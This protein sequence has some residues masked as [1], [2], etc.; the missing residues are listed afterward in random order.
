MNNIMK[1]SKDSKQ[2]MPRRE[3][4]KGSAAVSL[5]LTSGL[6]SIPNAFG[7]SSDHSTV[8]GQAG[9]AIQIEF[10]IAQCNP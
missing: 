8:S 2:N 3:F 4:I 1:N 5:G 6:F 10:R 9:N 7:Q